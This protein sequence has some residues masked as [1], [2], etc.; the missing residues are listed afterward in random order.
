MSCLFFVCLLFIALCALDM[1]LIKTTYLLTYWS[2]IIDSR[3]SSSVYSEL[4][5]TRRD[6]WSP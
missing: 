5:K 4:G 6:V 2:L 1:L 3:R